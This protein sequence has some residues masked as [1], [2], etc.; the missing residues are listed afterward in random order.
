MKIKTTLVILFL[1]FCQNVWGQEA[2]APNLKLKSGSN[3]LVSKIRFEN[4]DTLYLELTA[5][6]G[7][8]KVA[9]SDILTLDSSLLD[10]H[11]MSN[12]FKSRNARVGINVQRLFGLA[13]GFTL[14]LTTLVM[15]YNNGVFI[16]GVVLGVSGLIGVIPT[17][18]ILVNAQKRAK[19]YRAYRKAVELE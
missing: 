12:F 16:D 5:A 18:L 8:Y 1:W 9:N 14:S 15:V 6:D 3:H 13:T 11:K 4:R 2:T 17:V 19:D 10:K 7:Y